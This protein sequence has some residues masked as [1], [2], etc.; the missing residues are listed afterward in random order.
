[1][2]LLRQPR[3]PLSF[4]AAS[5]H[6]WLV[7]I[8]FI[9]DYP[10]VLL[11]KTALNTLIAQSLFMFG[12]VPVKVQNL[13]LVLVELNEI[14]MGPP[15]KPVKALLEIL[16]DIFFLQCVNCTT[17]LGVIHKLAEGTLLPLSTLV[18]L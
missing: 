17:C 5:T 14:H 8:F 12:I 15:F 3:M 18:L 16:S 13:T 10:Q 4:W 1:M 2:L 11:H 6:Y 9:H 7:F